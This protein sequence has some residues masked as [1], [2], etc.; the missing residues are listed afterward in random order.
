MSDEHAVQR[1][2]C[3]NKEVKPMMN[4]KQ[5]QNL[6]LNAVH[7]KTLRSMK[8]GEFRLKA[9]FLYLILKGIQNT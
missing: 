2:L 8:R 3:W 9:A 4:I 7:R 6:A 5:M 1:H